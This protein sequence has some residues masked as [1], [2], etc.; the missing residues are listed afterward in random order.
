MDYRLEFELQ[1][2]IKK[3]QEGNFDW[4]GIGTINMLNKKKSKPILTKKES[5]IYWNF[6]HMYKTIYVRFLRKSI[7][8][9]SDIV[10]ISN[11]K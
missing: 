7:S 4:T 3:A 5:Y 8:L 1:D 2:F 9:M 10:H 6:D 11:G